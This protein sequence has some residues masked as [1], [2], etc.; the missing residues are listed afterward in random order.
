[1]KDIFDRLAAL[2]GS[3][4]DCASRAREAAECIRAARNFHWVGLYEITPSRIVAIAWTGPVPPAFPALPRARG[5]NGAVAAK[6]PVVVQDVRNEPR[7]LALPRVLR[8]RHRAL[9]ARIVSGPG[10]PGGASKQ[11]LPEFPRS[12]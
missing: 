11:A 6:A 8:R 1:M 12:S 4:A 5:L 2:A 10:M 3:K 9:L 7:Y